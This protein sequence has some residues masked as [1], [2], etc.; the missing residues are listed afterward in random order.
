AGLLT[1]QPNGRLYQA[2]VEAKKA[3]TVNAL[4]GNSHDPA[5]FTASAQAVPEQLDAARDTL[6]QTI[7]ALAT[8]PFDQ[9]EIDKAKL[10][11]QRNAEL[12]QTNS[13]AMAQALSS[14]SALGDWRLLFLQRDRIQAVTASD[15]NRVAGTYFQ[16]PNRTVGMYIPTDR[17]ER[18][19]IAAAPPLDSQVKDYKGGS[20]AA[21]GEAFDPTPQNL[22][23]RTKFVDVNG[24]K[25]GL[26]QK[27]NRRETVALVLTL[28]HGNGE[29]P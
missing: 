9:T 16:K 6:L 29:S 23:A 21:A 22:D 3:T 8:T 5:L 28:H 27:K 1:Q 10:R 19:M 24:I 2:L 7:E 13:T 11:S 12:L 14:A 25:A 20:V 17:P 18:L 26:L 4:A 15:V